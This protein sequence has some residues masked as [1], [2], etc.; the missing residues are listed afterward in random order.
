MMNGLA[1]NEVAEDAERSQNAPSRLTGV[2]FD[3]WAARL[4][5]I[6]EILAIPVAAYWAFTR[7]EE[8]EKPGLEARVEFSSQ[9][10]WAEQPNSS[11]CV[12]QLKQR[13]RDGSR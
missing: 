12:A 10:D 6:L 7:F 8:G 13:A 4:K 2:A 11:E 9:L 1:F 3:R 5:L